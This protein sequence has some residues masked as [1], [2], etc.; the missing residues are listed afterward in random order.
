MRK[1]TFLILI[2]FNSFYLFAC[3]CIWSG[4][5]LTKA[6]KKELI[7]KVKIIEHMQNDAYFNEK[8]VVEI[9]EIFKGV[10]DRK[11]I[12]VWGDDGALCRP[13]VD[14]FKKDKEYYLALNKTNND[15]YQSNC[16]EYFLKIEEEKVINDYIYNLQLP[17]VSNMDI[18]T[19][20]IK[21]KEN[22]IERLE[23]ERLLKEYQNKK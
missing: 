14:Y 4:D 8:V 7:V 20:E 3:D 1:L 6:I 16:G 17:S 23:Y 11:R 13:Y 21:L 9:I 12:V 22:I 18:K 10:E 19:F 15:Y 2:F 5:F